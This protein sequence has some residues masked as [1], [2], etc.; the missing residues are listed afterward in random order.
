MQSAKPPSHVVARHELRA[1]TRCRSR[2]R[3]RSHAPHEITARARSPR[4]RSTPRRPRRGASTGAAHF[5]A[6]RQR[7]RAAARGARRRARNRCRC[8][9]RRIRRARALRRDRETGSG[10]VLSVSGVPIG[11][12]DRTAFMERSCPARG[13]AAARRFGLRTRRGRG[14]TLSRPFQSLACECRLP[15]ESRCG[16]GP[17]RSFSVS[18][19]PASR[20]G[21]L[22]AS[23][24]AS[25]LGSRFR[26]VRRALPPGDP[27][28]AG[29][30]RPSSI[31]PPPTGD[32]LMAPRWR[33]PRPWR[34]CRGNTPA[35]RAR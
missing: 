30:V 33:T 5:V 21:V 31:G 19:T 9:R 25:T 23:R 6:E 26:M 3:D 16:R 27:R 13:R 11:V 2:P 8:G 20:P 14:R 12:P 15:R 18:S 1:S 22:P 7:Q 32:Q 4:G 10:R 28:T 35:R 29:R 17:A 34:R 24:K